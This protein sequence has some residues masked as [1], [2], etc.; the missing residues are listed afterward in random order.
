MTSTTIWPRTRLVLADEI[1]SRQSYSG[2]ARTRSI[3]L[4]ILE[5]E[6][7]FFFWESMCDT[8]TDFFYNYYK[9]R[10]IIKRV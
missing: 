5:E 10:R 6:F 9:N 8:L 1:E 4:D 2:K 3:F 7:F